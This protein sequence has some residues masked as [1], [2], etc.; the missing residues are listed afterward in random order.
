MTDLLQGGAAKTSACAGPG[1]ADGAARVH[2]LPVELMRD[3]CTLTI[4]A[5]IGCCRAGP[6]RSVRVQHQVM[7][8]VLPEWTREAPTPCQVELMRDACA[9]HSCA[10]SPSFCRPG[11]FR[12]ACVQ[13]QVMQ[14]AQQLALPE[15]TREVLALRLGELLGLAC[16][17]LL[18]TQAELNTGVG[19]GLEQLPLCVQD[20]V[21]QMA[22]Q[23][24]LPECT[25]E[26]LTPRLVELIGEA[27]AMTQALCCVNPT[28]MLH[29]QSRRLDGP[30][31]GPSLPLPTDFW[32]AVLVSPH[33]RS[34]QSPLHVSLQADNAWVSPCRWSLP[35]LPQPAG[36]VFATPATAS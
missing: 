32:D 18:K 21:M 30:L 26:A 24:A 14:M 19:Q 6:T 11:L 5:I 4:H 8:M 10:M 27:C 12:S 29:L 13:D 33:M 9:I 25:R 16:V 36:M 22:Q 28:A 7:Q 35:P 3:V 15:C 1:E 17:M 34:A 23:L 2:A 31:E 20:Q